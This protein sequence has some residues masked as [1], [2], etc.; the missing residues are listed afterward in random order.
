MLT[1][2]VVQ[3]LLKVVDIFRFSDIFAVVFKLAISLTCLQKP[4]KVLHV[5]GCVSKR[6]LCWLSVLFGECARSQTVSLI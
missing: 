2:Y 1:N 6:L 5:E 4:A 3:A